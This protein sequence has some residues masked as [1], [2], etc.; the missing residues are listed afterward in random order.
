MITYMTLYDG[1]VLRLSFVLGMTT[2]LV[3]LIMGLGSTLQQ[4]KKI[5]DF[6]HGPAAVLCIEYRGVGNSEGVFRLD[7]PDVHTSDI[8]NI[9]DDLPLTASSVALVGVSFGSTIVREIYNRRVLPVTRMVLVSPVH[10]TVADALSPID[11]TYDLWNSFALATTA[12]VQNIRFSLPPRQIRGQWDQIGDDV[13]IL[14]CMASGDDQTFPSRS[15]HEIIAAGTKDLCVNLYPG[16]HGQETFLFDVNIWSQ[17]KQFLHPGWSTTGSHLDRSFRVR[18]QTVDVVNGKGPITVPSTMRCL[19]TVPSVVILSDY[20]RSHGLPYLSYI[21]SCQMATVV[22][23][24]LHMGGIVSNITCHGVEGTGPLY[25]YILEPKWFGLYTIKTWGMAYVDDDGLYHIPL[26]WAT[27]GTEIF[28]G[29]GR[30]HSRFLTP[31][32]SLGRMS[33]DRITLSIC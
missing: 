17:I 2:E 28:I 33:I 27:V 26:H 8:L 9:I 10:A 24:T 13:S 4:Y 3:V 14:V 29:F 1:T 23:C 5:A 7:A 6:I 32:S 25:A 30:Y 19:R 21:H 15:V 16:F 31:R 18:M 20:L 12:V 11:G 22:P